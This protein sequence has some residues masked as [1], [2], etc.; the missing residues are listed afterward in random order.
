[1]EESTPDWILFFGRFHPL[2]LH[3]PIGFLVLSFIIEI[4]SRFKRFGHYHA[5]VGFILA[6]GVAS[7]LVASLLG[8]MLAQ[9]GGYDED[10]LSFHQWTGIG[11]CVFSI[12]AVAI[13]QIR[14]RRPTVQMDRLYIG[15]MSAMVLT[16][17]VAGHYGGSLTHGSDYLTRYMPE[18]LRMIAGLPEQRSYEKKIITNLDSA[19]VYADI[20]D[21]ILYAHCTSCHNESK[22]KGD[23]MMHTPEAMLE[24]GETGQL[25]VPGVARNS[26]MIERILLPEDHDDH[27]PPKGKSQLSDDHVKLLTWW[28]S[29]GAPF[30]KRVSQ[31]NLPA[32]VKPVLDELVAPG[33]NKSEVEILLTSKANPVSDQALSQFQMKGVSIKPLS[34]EIHWLQADIAPFVAADSLLGSLKSVSEDV[35]WLSLSGTSTTDEGVSHIGKFKYL[36]RLHLGNTSITDNGLKHLNALSYLE[37]LNLYGTRVSD[38]GIQQISGLKNLRTL[39]LWRTDVTPQGVA[40]LQRALPNLEVNLGMR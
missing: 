39:Y 14:K 19:Y 34:S 15:A 3:I 31:V 21:P 33:A 38:E 27:M 24:G 2:I 7:A 16:I 29:E 35:T 30:D 8:L 10:I 40:R 11:V 32:D 13:R 28:I 17:A 25:F 36:T 9:G 1:M 4:I 18:G 6:L 23:L 26:L 12:A 22:R 20:I 5:P 37:S